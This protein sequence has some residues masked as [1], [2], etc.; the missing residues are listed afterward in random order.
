MSNSEQTDQ[1]NQ[2][3]PDCACPKCG[4]SDADMLIW[5]DDDRVRCFTCG[6]VYTPP[7]D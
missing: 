4:Q 1:G 3:T 6:T 2:V 7:A 5:I